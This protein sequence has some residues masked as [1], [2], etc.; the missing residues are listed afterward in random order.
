MQ[1]LERV[2]GGLVTA[3]FAFFVLATF[4][5]VVSRYVFA[6]SLGWVD[7]ACRYGFIWMVFLAAAIAARRGTHMAL[8]LLEEWLG[9]R[10][11]KPLLALADVALIA[12]A[13]LVG[14]GGFELMQLNWTA[15]SPATGI[16]IAWVQLIL[17]VFGVLTCLFAGEHLFRVLSRPGATAEPSKPGAGI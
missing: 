5:Q 12:F 7:E 1:L 4:W 8:T 9:P 13:V 3:V 10:A 14:W 2:V 15:L 16:P 11:N 6:T 17:P